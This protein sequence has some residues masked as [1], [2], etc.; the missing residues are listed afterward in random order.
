[1][2]VKFLRK[3]MDIAKCALNNKIYIAV[4]FA[5]LPASELSNK[6]KSLICT[7]CNA[8]A[9]FRKASSSGQAACFGARPHMENC[10]FASPETQVSE[11][12]GGDEDIIHNPGQIIEIDLN[13]GASN[14]NI[15]V[16]PNHGGETGQGRGRHVG[17]GTRPNANMHRRLST[18]LRN[19]INSNEF[20][21][22]NQ[23]I[24]LEGRSVTSVSDF[25]MN[26]N[27]VSGAKDGE[28]HGY[29]GMLTDARIGNGGTLW[30]NSGGKS[31][32]S[33]AI[34]HQDIDA[35]YNRYSIDDEEGFAGVYALIIGEK[36]TSQ[37]GKQ[38][39]RIDSIEHLVVRP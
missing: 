29:W 26:F 9:F 4:N 27:D 21:N 30:L 8:D 35:L 25:F 34:S 7:E 10:S 5:E 31:A 16:G 6:R 15:D 20:R 3:Y 22:S 17:R 19:L 14:Q 36:G 32:V 24:K 2:F 28:F 11:A 39:I 1:M 38:Y 23:L 12:E 37:N 33:C 13:F 18:L